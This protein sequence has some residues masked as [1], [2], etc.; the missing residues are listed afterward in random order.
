VHVLKEAVDIL[1]LDVLILQLAVDL[2]VSP[3]TALVEHDQHEVDI[4]LPQ[5]ILLVFERKFAGA[6][7]C[8]LDA[9][10]LPAVDGL[11]LI[12]PERAHAQFDYLAIDLHEVFTGLFRQM[13]ADTVT[14]EKAESSTVRQESLNLGLPVVH[15]VIHVRAERIFSHQAV[16][17]ADVLCA[18]VDIG[19]LNFLS[20]PSLSKMV[21]GARF[22]QGSCPQER[23][24]RVETQSQSQCAARL[25]C[26]SYEAPH[27]RLLIR[28]NLNSEI[29]VIDDQT[30]RLEGRGVSTL[31]HSWA[32]L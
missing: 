16:V 2:V 20:D 27:I 11:C 22:V 10:F 18:V 31:E 13:A 6:V 12:F 25:S 29:G 7:P 4:G 24:L 14:Q 5:R 21:L 23:L 8:G 32:R 15:W 1:Q 19:T 26:L 9:Y 17:I 28:D 3:N 30:L